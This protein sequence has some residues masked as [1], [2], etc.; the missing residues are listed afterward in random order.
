[1]NTTHADED[2][3]PQFRL[4][5][6]EGN[7]SNVEEILRH[8]PDLNAVDEEGVALIVD[9]ALGGNVKILQ[10]LLDAGADIGPAMECLDSLSEQG[11]EDVADYLKRVWITGRTKSA[12]QSKESRQ[13]ARKLC[14]IDKHDIEIVKSW[15]ET[16]RP[17]FP[18]HISE[19]DIAPVPPPKTSQKIYSQVFSDAFENSDSKQH[20]FLKWFAL[21]RFLVDV[22]P[23]QRKSMYQEFW[24]YEAKIVIPPRYGEAKSAKGGI[25]PKGNISSVH[26]RVIRADV[27]ANGFS[28]ECGVTRAENLIDPIACEAVKKTIWIPF[29]GI[30]QNEDWSDFESKIPAYQIS[31][32]KQKK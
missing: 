18:V 15:I 27:V 17:Q 28:I 13:K 8:N 20:G 1:M 21:M 23:Q 25:L 29:V 6:L 31:R 12:E 5:C 16:A 11:L 14:P 24:R 32:A 10:R 4:A 2:I 9:A 7:L 30:D 26:G 22:I 3:D 19:I